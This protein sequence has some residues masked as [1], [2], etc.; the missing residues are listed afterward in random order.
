[1]A[2]STTSIQLQCPTGILPAPGNGTQILDAERRRSIRAYKS[3]DEYLHA[4]K[5]D[6]S[7]WL[8]SLYE[9]ST[10]ADDLL[11]HLGT[12]SLLCRHAEKVQQFVNSSASSA[13]VTTDDGKTGKR[14]S[15][16]PLYLTGSTLSNVGTTA[17]LRHGQV[18]GFSET[19]SS[20]SESHY[21][22]KEPDNGVNGAV[23]LADKAWLVSFI[24]HCE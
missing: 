16:E 1:M 19:A 13:S 11:D 12:G 17:D 24:V 8:N 5:E 9:L 21:L 7:E 20:S 4:M 14:R 23:E 10:T 2:R 6:L 15:N 18:S 22:F 3:S